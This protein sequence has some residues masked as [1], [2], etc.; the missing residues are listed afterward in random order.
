LNLAPTG[1][2][3]V[4]DLPRGQTLA[5]ELG[6]NDGLLGDGDCR[7]FAADLAL[8]PHVMDLDVRHRRACRPVLWTFCTASV[9][10]GKT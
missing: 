9:N 6:D 4:D 2:G 3:A 10:Q 5:L 8:Q 7:Y 1:A